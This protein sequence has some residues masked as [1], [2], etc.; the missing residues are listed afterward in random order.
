MQDPAVCLQVYRPLEE[1]SQ[2][3]FGVQANIVVKQFD[4]QSL[5]LAG[6]VEQ[7]GEQFQQADLLCDLWDVS[8]TGGGGSK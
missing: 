3:P 5:F 1:L 2:Q 7:H 6:S 8:E 4:V